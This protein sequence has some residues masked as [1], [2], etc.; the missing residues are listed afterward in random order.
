MTDLWAA[1]RD[2]LRIEPLTGE[3]LRMVESQEQIAT[4]SLVDDLAEQA[5]L[6]DLLERAKP[7]L[8]V[9]TD[10]LHY[11]LAT[12]FRYPPLRHGSRFGRRF[13]PG[14]F[15]GARRLPTLLAEAVGRRAACRRHRR[16]RVQLS[17]GPRRGH[18]PRALFSRGRWPAAARWS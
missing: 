8:P 10:G 7:P 18:Q 15:Y 13:E 17:P 12:P 4:L 6:E 5:V 14:L 1:C 9:G 3:L 2:V 11:L 16:L